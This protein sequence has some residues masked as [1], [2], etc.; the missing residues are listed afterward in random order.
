MPPFIGRGDGDDSDLERTLDEQ[1]PL[2]DGM[3][4]TLATVVCPYCAEPV[5]IA[6]DPGS[7]A[8]QDYVED[9]QVCCQPWQ[10]RVVY[11]EDGRAKVA[12]KALDA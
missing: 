10:V 5:E 7:G 4:E 9:C 12:I 8:V 3:A 1:F 2:G 11:R 6:L